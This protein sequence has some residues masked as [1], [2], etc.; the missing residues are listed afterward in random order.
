MADCLNEEE[1]SDPGRYARNLAFAQGWSPSEGKARGGIASP[2]PVKLRRGQVRCLMRVGHSHYKGNRVPD[3]VNLSSPWWMADQTFLD[4]GQRA[5]ESGARMQQMVRMK[6][7]I[8]PDFGVCDTVFWV[9]LKPGIA[10]R[11]FVG[12]GFPVMES[13]D[14]AERGR[15]D[16]PLAWLGDHE[17][18]QYFIPGLRSY[19]PGGMKPAA[20]INDAFD[21]LPPQPVHRWH[22]VVRGGF[23]PSRNT[24]HA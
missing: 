1:F 4:I 11:A 5:A 22:R 2:Q 24:I 17:V 23:R 20:I 12:R 14:P 10:L 7:A 6:L 8:T 9:E 21:V 3:W 19:G 16:R 18:P 13:A 15:Q